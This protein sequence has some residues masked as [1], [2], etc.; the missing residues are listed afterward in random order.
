MPSTQVLAVP[1]NVTNQ[2]LV[3]SSGIIEEDG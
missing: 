2:T 1:K 3:L